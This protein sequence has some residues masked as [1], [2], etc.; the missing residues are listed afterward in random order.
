[1]P[2]RWLEIAEELFP[3]EPFSE[4]DDRMEVACKRIQRLEEDNA[5]LKAQLADDAESCDKCSG[6]PMEEVESLRNQLEVWKTLVK[7]LGG[8]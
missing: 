6:V 1:M 4:W 8:R 2:E 3:N 7:M 5:H